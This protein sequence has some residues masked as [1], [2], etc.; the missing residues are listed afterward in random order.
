MTPIERRDTCL[1]FAQR[2]DQELDKGGNTMIAAELMWGAVAQ[3]LLA[4]AE[5][6]EWPSQG[7][8]GY[9]R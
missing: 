1:E 7:H 2:S 3:A 6:N 9:F 8:R 4:V 5:I